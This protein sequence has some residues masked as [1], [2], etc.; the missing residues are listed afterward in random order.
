MIRKCQVEQTPHYNLNEVRPIDPG[1]ILANELR[2]HLV[3]ELM[4]WVEANEGV[5]I[6]DD[7]R[8][9]GT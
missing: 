3:R 7:L 2:L 8:G 1:G 6:S 4:T 5:E 9:G